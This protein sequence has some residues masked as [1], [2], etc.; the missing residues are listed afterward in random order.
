MRVKLQVVCTSPVL[1]A[2]RLRR[3]STGMDLAANPHLWTRL[4][5]DGPQIAR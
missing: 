5:Q 2:G 3:V 4:E 1:F